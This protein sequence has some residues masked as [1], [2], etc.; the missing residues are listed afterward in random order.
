MKRISFFLWLLMAALASSG[1]APRWKPVN[2]FTD[3]PREIPLQ[4]A[5]VFQAMPLDRT[6]KAMLGRWAADT[7]MAL[8]YRHPSDFT[9]HKPVAQVRATR[10][11]DALLE[12][13]AAYGQR[14]SLAVVGNAITVREASTIEQ[15]LIPARSAGR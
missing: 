13:E 7:G 9:L 11:A 15:A 12:L 3:E 8:A 2:R 14:L 10:L 5:Y 4:Q 6:L 1:C